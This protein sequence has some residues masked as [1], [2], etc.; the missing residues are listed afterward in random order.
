MAKNIY[1]GKVSDKRGRGR[2]RMTFENSVSKILEEGHV[3]SMK[4]P[5]RA[6]MKRLMTVDEAKEMC[7]DRS[8][9]RPVL[10]DYPARDRA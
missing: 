8:V 9:W 7:R 2:S 10:S 1:D 3:K 5:R 4:I 6:C